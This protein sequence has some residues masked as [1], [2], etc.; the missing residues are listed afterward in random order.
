MLSKSAAR[1]RRLSTRMAFHLFEELA[2]KHS[3]SEYHRILSER[4][5]LEEWVKQSE[6]LRRAKLDQVV[7]MCRYGPDCTSALE[8]VETLRQI[9][10]RRLAEELFKQHHDDRDCADLRDCGVEGE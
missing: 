6:S 4:E 9:A 5:W 8:I 7:L 3:V 2:E 1:H 10:S